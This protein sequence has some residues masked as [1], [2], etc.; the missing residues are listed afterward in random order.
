MWHILPSSPLLSSPPPSPAQAS[1]AV[2]VKEAQ[3]E[4]HG[5]TIRSLK[6]AAAAAEE[7]ARASEAGLREAVQ[8]LRVRLEDAQRSADA[9]AYARDEAL[10][11]A[12]RAGAAAA[13]AHAASSQLEAV[14]AGLRADVGATDA[15][16]KVPGG[17]GRRRVR[18]CVWGRAA[19]LPSRP[20]RSLP[21]R[22]LPLPTWAERS[23]ASLPL[24]R[25]V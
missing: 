7:G 11:E 24:T 3:L 4:D 5:H 9:A 6:R 20:C 12:R 23:A 15:L 25:G 16:R 10:A 18:A 22:R 21:P 14:V 1:S 13:A 2:K 17:A 19:P 8:E